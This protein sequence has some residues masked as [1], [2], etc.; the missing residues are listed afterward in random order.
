[1]AQTKYVL[2]RALSLGLTPIVVIN[3]VDREDGLTRLESGETESELLDLFD[4]LGATDEQMDYTT[5]YGSARNGWITKDQDVAFSLAT[6]RNQSSSDDVG[7]NVLLDHILENISEPIVQSYTKEGT[8]PGEAFG[9]DKFSL[10]AVT[11]GYD[12]YLGRTCTGRVQSGSIS[13][14]DDLVFLKAA[15]DDTIGSV[16]ASETTTVSGI[17]VNRGIS[18]TPLG[19]TAYAGDIVTISGVPDSIA[20]G[21]TLTNPSNPV[22][23]PLKTLPVAPPILAMEFGANDGPLGGLEG[24]EVTPSK[25]RSRLIAETDNNVTLAVEK[26]KESDK[27][28]VFARGEL[29]LGILIEQMRREGYEVIISPPKIVT[30]MAPDGKTILEP[31]EEVTV[32]VDTEYA[33]AIVSALTGDRKGLLLEM[34]DS[35]GKTRLR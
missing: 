7:M 12:A 6:E 19:S 32:D 33:G 17:F 27:T 10:A 13:M 35:A 8:K 26:S 14:G 20:V 28:T 29:Q 22:A 4:E 21:D 3:K 5:L 16:T 1:M 34:H 15:R 25:I 9:S 24:T 30:K 11:V 31:F 18:R 23:S 2:S